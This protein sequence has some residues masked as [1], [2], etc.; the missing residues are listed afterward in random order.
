MT[1]ADHEGPVAFRQGARQVS[2]KG[3]LHAKGMNAIGIDAR[4]P[5]QYT[6]RNHAA[7]GVRELCQFLLSARQSNALANH[8][9]IRDRLDPPTEFGDDVAHRDRVLAER[10]IGDLLGQ[11]LEA[12]CGITHFGKLGRCTI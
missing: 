1:R 6:I 4:H 5:N 8:N 2:H 9:P 10:Q 7:C 11:Q 3:T 12:L